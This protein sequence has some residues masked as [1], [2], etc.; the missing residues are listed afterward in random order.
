MKRQVIYTRVTIAA[1]CKLCE[2]IK[3]YQIDLIKL[4]Q[5]DIILWNNY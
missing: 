3:I 4:E 1:V 5:C 2:I